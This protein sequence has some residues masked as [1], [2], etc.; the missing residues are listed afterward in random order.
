M[1]RKTK[2]SMVSAE[3]LRNM[4]DAVTSKI[5]DMIPSV[6]IL[7][8][9]IGLA[10]GNLTDVSQ[11]AEIVSYP[12]AYAYEGK[13]LASKV[14]FA[15]EISEGVIL[16]ESHDTFFAV[17]KRVAEKQVAPTVLFKIDEKAPVFI[18]CT[19]AE[20]KKPLAFISHYEGGGNVQFYDPLKKEQRSVTLP[21][22]IE[23]TTLQLLGDQEA[24]TID[25]FSGQLHFLSPKI[26][27]AAFVDKKHVANLTHAVTT[28]VDAA[29][30]RMIFGGHTSQLGLLD[31]SDRNKP[32]VLW[33]SKYL[34][35]NN[36]PYSPYQCAFS[37]D[38]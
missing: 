38:G 36:Y 28:T 21:L 32:K 1:D 11:A 30:K 33:V 37:D 16:I 6:V 18:K 15:Y 20:D 13:S 22:G 23:P 29:G 4:G 26:K 24:V 19:A 14:S 2:P 9:L 10:I 27:S 25:S 12:I 35:D 8:I 5:R 17:P 3:I 31:I 7:L 34:N